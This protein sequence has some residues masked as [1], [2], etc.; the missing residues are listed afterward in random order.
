[1][2]FVCFTIFGLIVF[3]CS[4]IGY[5]NFRSTTLYALAIGG[6]VN[7]N[8]FHAGNYPINCFGLT[9]GIDSLIYIL[10]VFCVVVMLLKE[11]KKSAYLLA[12]SGIIAIMFSALMQLTSSLLSVGSSEYVWN[13]FFTFVISCIA[14]VIALFVMIETIN[15]IKHKFNNYWVMLIGIL[16]A[17]IIDSALYYPLAA[18]INGAP[19]N[20]L[21]LVLT[22][23]IGKAIA[24]LF[25]LL[26]LYLINK[27]EAKHLNKNNNQQ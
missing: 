19:E 5:K 14:S 7:A 17:I 23:F 16:I 4:L 13:T 24:L 27:Y 15:K 10:F 26:T 3:L 1:M 21:S 11:N 20:I 25:S 8:F 18:L 12:F 9:F 6:A 2:N 22:S